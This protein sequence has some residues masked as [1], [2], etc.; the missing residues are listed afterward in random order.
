MIRYSNVIKKSIIISFFLLLLIVGATY[1]AAKVKA[2]THRVDPVCVSSHMAYLA[3]SDLNNQFN[4]MRQG[5]IQWTR[6]DWFWADMEPSQGTYNFS[7]YDN[8]VTTANNYGIKIIAMVP[9]YGIPSWYRQDSSNYFSPPEDMQNY[10][11][12][13]QALATHFKGKILLYELG[14]EP[15]L[16]GFWQPTPNV[17]SFSAMVKAGYIGVKTG[18]PNAKVISGGISA[19]NPVPFVQGMYANGIKGSFDYLGLHP[20]S[21]PYSPDDTTNYPQF[22]AISVIKNVMTGSGDTSQIMATEIGWPSTLESGGVTE[23]TQAYYINRVYQKIEYEAYQYVPIACIY[24]F[25]D[26]GTDRTNPEDNFGIMHYDWTMKPSYTI[27]QQVR[28]NYNQNFI[29]INP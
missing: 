26:D 25:I 20:Y 5:G 16:A 2:K 1:S 28:A 21:W 6:F 13:M 19:A 7:K 15:D 9:Q 3:Q 12:F 24:D 10:G 4:L 22:A 8:I 23:D 29:P 11:T 18:D 27:M 17:A 14:N